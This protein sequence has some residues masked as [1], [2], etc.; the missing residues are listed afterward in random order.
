MPGSISSDK[1]F[2][3]QNL[4]IP[5]PMYDCLHLGN[6]YL[7]RNKQQTMK[8]TLLL[9]LT[10]LVLFACQKEDQQQEENGS[11]PVTQEYTCPKCGAKYS[12]TC[13]KPNL[14]GKIGV[15]IGGGDWTLITNPSG[16]KW[17]VTDESGQNV[18]HYEYW[19]RE[20]MYFTCTCG[21][22]SKEFNIDDFKTQIFKP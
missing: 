19:N 4:L 21:K 8:K 20:K 7:C 5:I 3:K 22:N 1:I 16:G 10:S 6:D 12:V 11:E 15:H 13:K 14:G 2:Q 9:I 18:S 17:T